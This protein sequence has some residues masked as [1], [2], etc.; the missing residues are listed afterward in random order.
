MQPPEPQS[1]S[2]TLRILNEA[3]K[4]AYLCEARL[5]P[6]FA[7]LEMGM[8]ERMAAAAIME[9]RTQSKND[10]QLRE[11]VMNQLDWE[12]EAPSAE[13]GVSV[14]EG[15]VTLTGFVNTY[16]QLLASCSCA[17]HQTGA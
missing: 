8:G 14:S 3:A 4:I 6:A 12:P 5:L 13:I 7:N 16:G 9:A 10:H 1:H 15:V 17:I 2:A 11:A